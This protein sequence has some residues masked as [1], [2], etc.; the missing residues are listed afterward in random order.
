M[1]P[2]LLVMVEI[3]VIVDV[4]RVAPREMLQQFDGHADGHRM[5]DT[6]LGMFAEQCAGPTAKVL[7]NAVE[8]HRVDVVDVDFPPHRIAHT[9]ALIPVFLARSSNVFQRIKGVHREVNF[10]QRGRHLSCQR[11]LAVVGID[12]QEILARKTGLI[13][14]TRL[15]GVAELV[16]SRHGVV[17][18]EVGA[19]DVDVGREATARMRLGVLTVCPLNPEVVAFLIVGRAF[20]SYLIDSES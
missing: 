11:V 10:G 14:D 2:L 3:H 18:V 7:P 1:D 15:E 12:G 8:E 17:L 9:Q 13:A 19:D 6:H 5:T 4:H 16:G 20:G